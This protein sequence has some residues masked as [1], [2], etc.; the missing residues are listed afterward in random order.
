MRQ[1]PRL[2]FTDAELNPKLREHVRRAEKAADKA[3]AAR[4]KVPKVKKK[5]KRTTIDPETGKSKA[6]LCFEE[7]D[8]VKSPSKLS[9]T[10]RDAPGNTVAGAVHREVR[11]SEDDNVGVESAHRLEEAAETGGRL[12]Q[13]SYRAQ[14]LKPYREAA[15]AERRLGKANVNALYQKHIRDNPQL[16]SNPLSRWQQKRAIQKQYAPLSVPVRVPPPLWRIPP[17]PRKRLRRNPKTA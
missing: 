16:S 2:Q 7:V 3:E 8:K 10:V 6:R 5:I 14:K 11:Q 4:T 17:R 12:A 1:N 9:H 13:R 15:K